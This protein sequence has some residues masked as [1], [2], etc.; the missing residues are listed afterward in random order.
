[1]VIKRALDRRAESVKIRNTTN[2]RKKFQVGTRFVL[3]KQLLHLNNAI[4]IS[5][6]D[7]ESILINFLKHKKT[8]RFRED[9]KLTE[10]ELENGDNLIIDENVEKQ[11]LNLISKRSAILLSHGITPWALLEIL[12]KEKLYY[13]ENTKKYYDSFFSKF[14]RFEFAT[15]VSKNPKAFGN[16]QLK[17]KLKQAFKVKLTVALK[18]LGFSTEFIDNLV[19]D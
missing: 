10:I 15:I 8:T 1:M 12:P 5:Q 18:K 14:L 16:I 7:A 6:K 9:L 17:Q 2:S 11:Y 4:L 13:S 19:F 3:D